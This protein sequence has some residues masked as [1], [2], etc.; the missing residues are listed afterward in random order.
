M[1]IEVTVNTATYARSDELAT[2]NLEKTIFKPKNKTIY[3]TNDHLWCL[4]N[5]KNSAAKKAKEV[6]AVVNREKGRERDNKI[7]CNNLWVF[8]I[9]VLLLVII[10]QYLHD[11]V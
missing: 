8:N 3:F 7:L 6:Q 5:W 11:S 9:F 2:L 10:M 4:K 1:Y